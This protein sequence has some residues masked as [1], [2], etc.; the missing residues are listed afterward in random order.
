MKNQR[1]LS[2]EDITAATTPSSEQANHTI[3][4]VGYESLNPGMAN[5]LARLYSERVTKN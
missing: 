5:P 2:C 4:F 3:H 1:N